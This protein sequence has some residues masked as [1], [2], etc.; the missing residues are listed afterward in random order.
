M[1]VAPVSVAPVSVAPVSVAPVSVAPVSPSAGSGSCTGAGPSRASSSLI[2]ERATPN[3]SAMAC[4]VHPDPAQARAWAT[5]RPVSL[6]GRPRRRT[7]PT[8]PSRRAR[9]RSIDTYVAVNPN[10][11]AT[12]STRRPASV[13]ATI[14]RFRIPTSSAS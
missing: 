6:G 3:R 12:S 4:R 2:T 10:T 8:E 5:C 9:P 1:S 14:A 13:N 11:A 7:S